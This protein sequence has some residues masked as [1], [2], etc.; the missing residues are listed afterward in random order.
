MNKYYEP[1][2]VDKEKLSA[3]LCNANRQQDIA[4]RACSGESYASIGKCYGISRQRVETILK[5]LYMRSDALQSVNS[6][7]PTTE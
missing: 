4:Y 5:R 3:A 6:S 7:A 1:V 2:K